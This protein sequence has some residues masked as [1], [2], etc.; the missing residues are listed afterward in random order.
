MMLERV[1]KDT[2]LRMQ[3]TIEVLKADLG[4][5]RTGRA[6]TGLIEHVQ[7]E[8]YG[9]RVPLSQVATIAVGDARNLTITPWE[10]GVVPAV[11]KAILECGLGLNPV[12]AGQTIRVPLPPLTEERRKE[13][14]RLARHEGESAKVSVRNVRRDSNNHLKE[15]LKKKEISEDDEKYAQDIVQKIT[16][17][18]IAEVDRLVA[19]KEHEI[20]AI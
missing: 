18:F 7:V 4:K 14:G 8:Y 19:A 11:E 10:K 16:D 1:K 20:L 6:S 17:H 12:T 5:I 15:L 9:A 3:K 13:L 2:E